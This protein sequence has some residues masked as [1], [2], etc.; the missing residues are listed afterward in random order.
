MRT[1][2]ASEADHEAGAQDKFRPLAI[3]SRKSSPT[4]ELQRSNTSGMKSFLNYLA[5]NWAEQKQS[6]RGS[7]QAAENFKV[8]KGAAKLTQY[9]SDCHISGDI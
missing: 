1:A 8:S 2:I 7:S 6:G 5:G 3:N 4:S 9:L